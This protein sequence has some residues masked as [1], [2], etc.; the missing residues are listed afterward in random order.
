MKY[1][2]KESH[3]FNIK[4]LIVVIKSY[5]NIPQVNKKTSAMTS[6]L[7]VCCF[8][9]GATF[10]ISPCWSA[11]QMQLPKS[12]WGHGII[13]YHRIITQQLYRHQLMKRASF[14]LRFR[15]CKTQN[16]PHGTNTAPSKIFGVVVKR[17]LKVQLRK[18]VV[19][20]I[21]SLIRLRVGQLLFLEKS[22]RAI[23]SFALYLKEQKSDSLFGALFERAIRSLALFW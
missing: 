13:I 4:L 6:I 10:P 15:M 11:F 17:C 5:K 16:L 19:F 18:I 12:Y 2:I 8:P 21:F 7:E 22:K 14:F 9:P 3:S 23:R 20:Y 1:F